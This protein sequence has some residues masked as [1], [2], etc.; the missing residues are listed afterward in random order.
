MAFFRNNFSCLAQRGGYPSK[1]PKKLDMTAYVKSPTTKDQSVFF[2]LR[3]EIQKISSN[4]SR[5][6]LYGKYDM[7]LISGNR[8][9][10]VDTIEELN[11]VIFKAAAEIAAH[12]MEEG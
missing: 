1:Q 7:Y 5:Y 9:I 10:V 4:Y 3:K 11:E 12:Q 8:L 6:K 2:A